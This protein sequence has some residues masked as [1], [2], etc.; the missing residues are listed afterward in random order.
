[1]KLH[2]FSPVWSHGLHGGD[3]P[4]HSCGL[5]GV[6]MGTP[7]GGLPRAS[8]TTKTGRGGGRA[9][10]GLRRLVCGVDRDRADQLGSGRGVQPHGRRRRDMEPAGGPE[11]QARATAD[12]ADNPAPAPV[13]ADLDGGLG[14]GHGL[15]QPARRQPRHHRGALSPTVAPHG[16]HRSTAH[17]FRDL[18][19]VNTSPAVAGDGAGRWCGVGAASLVNG[20]FGIECRHLLGG[21]GRQRRHMAARSAVNAAAADTP[22]ADWSPRSQRT[23]PAHGSPCGRTTLAAAASTAT[24][25]CR[26]PLTTARRGARPAPSAPRVIM[27]RPTRRWT[28]RR[29]WRLAADMGG[30]VVGQRANDDHRSLHIHIQVARSTN[31][32]VS[33]GAPRRSRPPDQP[34]R[35]DPRQWLAYGNGAFT[36]AWLRLEPAAAARV[37]SSSRSMAGR[38]GQRPPRPRRAASPPASPSRPMAPSPWRCRRQRG[39]L[40]ATSCGPGSS[41]RRQARQTGSCTSRLAWGPPASCDFRRRPAPR[42]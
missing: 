22:V 39:P 14:H 11:R 33:F 18:L 10:R 12:Q 25:S 32:S 35:F 1:M 6:R 15:G 34:G 37:L 26:A 20:A 40:P 3:S 27:A 13:G 24:S 8:N 23:A 19:L 28:C 21:F 30:G 16:A 31:G 17:G 7:H 2:R 38:H 5:R 4:L 42:S 29:P 9:G 36:L 41:P